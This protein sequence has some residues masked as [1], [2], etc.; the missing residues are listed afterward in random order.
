[1][2][3]I[4]IEII[5]NITSENNYIISKNYKNV[6]KNF[7]ELLLRID[8]I[9]D[10][11]VNEKEYSLLLNNI[12]LSRYNKNLDLTYRRTIVEAFFNKITN[13]QLKFILPILK[14]LIN[15]VEPKKLDDEKESLNSFMSNFDVT[16]DDL[17]Y[18][19]YDIIMKKNNDILNLN[20]LYYFEC[21]CDLYFRKLSKDNGTVFSVDD[22]NVPEISSGENIEEESEKS[23]LRRILIECIKAL[24]EPDSTI[25]IQKFYYKKTSHQIADILSMKPSGVRMRCKRAADKLKEALAKRG[26]KEDAI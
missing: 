6:E 23:E 16:N 22:E 17:E 5:K 25:I 13:Q 11:K 4:F 7:I 21:E 19:I 15:D 12:F 14:K 26:I 20:I 24:G 10:A 9:F 3:I 18:Y 1:M 8:N 2:R